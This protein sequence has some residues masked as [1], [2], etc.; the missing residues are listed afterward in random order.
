[1]I[2]INFEAGEDLRNEKKTR[3]AKKR[4]LYIGKQKEIIGMEECIRGIPVCIHEPRRS[5][6]TRC[7]NKQIQKSPG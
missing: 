6:I 5:S 3:E 7:N 1:M 4:R 2:L